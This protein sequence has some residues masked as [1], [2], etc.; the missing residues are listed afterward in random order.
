MGAGPSRTRRRHR[1]G[2]D[3]RFGARAHQSAYGPEPGQPGRSPAG[4]P[5]IGTWHR[6]HLGQIVDDDAID[7]PR[8]A[9]P[10]RCWLAGRHRRKR[11]RRAQFAPGRIEGP[12]VDPELRCTTASPRPSDRG[13]REVSAGPRSMAVVDQNSI[14][15]PRPPFEP[16]LTGQ[17]GPAFAS[18][19]NGSGLCA[20]GAWRGCRSRRRTAEHASGRAGSSDGQAVYQ[21]RGLLDPRL[22]DWRSEAEGL[23][24]GDEVVRCGS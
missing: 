19:R 2:G 23:R 16:A 24:P 3:V 10:P 22:T 7:A 9:E 11:P 1:L 5:S 14:E 20:A 21:S 15:P 18:N 4:R 17:L 8:W 6:A 13:R 12:A